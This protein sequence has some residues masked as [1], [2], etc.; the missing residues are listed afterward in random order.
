ML[1]KFFQNIEE[2]VQT[3]FASIILIPRLDKDTT[4]KENCRPLPFMNIVGKILNKI[5]VNRIQEHFGQYDQV[6]FITGM[7]GLFVIY[8][9]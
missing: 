8:A 7:Q 3:H 6:G 4:R 1:L 5:L 2:H 9:N